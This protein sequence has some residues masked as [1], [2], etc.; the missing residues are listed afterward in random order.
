MNLLINLSRIKGTFLIFDMISIIITFFTLLYL[1]F[2][3]GLWLE[4]YGL[5][6]KVWHY[7][8]FVWD[9]PFY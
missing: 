5:I 8:Q 9:N 2:F 6:E 3:Q 1:F 7:D 4:K